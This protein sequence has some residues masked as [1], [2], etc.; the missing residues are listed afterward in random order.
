MDETYVRVKGQWTYLY[1]AIDKEGKPL[2]FILSERRDEAA[3]TSHCVFHKSYRQKRPAR[4]GRYRQKWIKYGW[5][6]QLEL[7]AC[8]V[9]L[10]S[11]YHS[12]ADQISQ[13][14]Y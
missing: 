6:I 3:A 8:D 9:R 2:D 4:Q 5:S 1:R 10:V 14:H 13:Q 7:P 12:S 11:V